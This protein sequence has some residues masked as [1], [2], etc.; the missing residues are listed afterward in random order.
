MN[1]RLSST[2]IRP[3]CFYCQS[4]TFKVQV[5]VRKTVDLSDEMSCI[6]SGI[7]SVKDGKKTRNI[8]G[9]RLLSLKEKV[10]KIWMTGDFSY[11]IDTAVLQ[12]LQCNKRENI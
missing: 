6:D 5:T 10:E 1:N 9:K 12:R 4:F 11:L 2:G 3:G 7:D 8:R